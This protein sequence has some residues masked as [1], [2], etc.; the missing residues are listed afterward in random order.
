[1]LHTERL[2]VGFLMDPLERV[3]VH[4][5]TTFALML[6]TQARGH[7][8]LCFE[9]HHLSYAHRR[10]QVLAREVEVQAVPG[11]HFRVVA[12]LTLGIDA[13]DVLWLRKD[14]PVDAAFLHATQLV[15][16]STE[17]AP[18]FINSPSGL[19]AANEHLWGLRFPEL[20]PPTL[21]SADMAELKGFIDLAPDGAVLKPVEGHGG[22][23]VV[24]LTKGDRNTTALLELYTRRGT[25]W[26]MLQRYLPEARV[27][28]KRILVLDGQPL[29]AV[30]RVPRDDDHRGNLAAGG[31][32]VRSALTARDRALCEHLA[33]HLKAEGLSFVGLDVIGD[34]LTE[35]NVTSPTGLVEIAQLDGTPLAEQVV[36]AVEKKARARGDAASRAPGVPGR[37]RP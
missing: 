30:L 5:D 6:A 33:P 35:V 24:L 14:P 31:K 25:E 19:R 23:G 32:A 9:Q 18:L 21:V 11:A 28:D 36:L 2:T 8:I 1:V 37:A 12:T 29:G 27:G 16:T 13:L 4:H 15:E 17:G 7:R 22:E 10:P 3:L 26:A 20:S 34:F